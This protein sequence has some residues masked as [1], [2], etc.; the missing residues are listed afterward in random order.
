[1]ISIFKKF[2]PLWQNAVTRFALAVWRGNDD[3]KAEKWYDHK[4]LYFARE[5]RHALEKHYEKKGMRIYRGTI[6]GYQNEWLRRQQTLKENLRIIAAEKQ[7]KLVQ[8]EI[9]RLKNEKDPQKMIDRLYGAK[10][11]EEIYKIFSFTDELKDLAAQKGDDEAYALGTGINEIVIKAHSN[12]Y[13]WR[14][15]RDARVRKTHQML[16]DKCFLF[17]DPPKTIDRYGNEHTGN[18]GSDW[19]CR[20]WADLAPEREKALRH[21]VVREK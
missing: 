15:Q 6:D 14:S 1:M 13:F 11:N 9:E 4:A 16:A 7:D 3:E 18:P 8:D 12:R 19:G 5:Y 10:E 20:C 21:H 17:D 2:A